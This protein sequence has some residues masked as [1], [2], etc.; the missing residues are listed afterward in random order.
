MINDSN[1]Y[2][3]NKKGEK[4]NNILIIE[5]HQTTRKGLASLL[6]NS[7]YQ[8][9]EADNGLEA[10]SMITGTRYDLI[11]IDLFLPQVNGLK[12]LKKTNFWI[13]LD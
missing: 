1:L 10:E 12:L 8:V 4:M 13:P 3:L 7:G 2:F 5:D 11:L 9:D 6:K